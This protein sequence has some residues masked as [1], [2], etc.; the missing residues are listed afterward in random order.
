VR[1]LHLANIAHH[2]K[3]RAVLGEDGVTVTV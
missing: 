1:T 3:A 2:K